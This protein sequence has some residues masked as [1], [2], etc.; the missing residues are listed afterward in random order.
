MLLKIVQTTLHLSASFVND[1]SGKRVNSSPESV[2]IDNVV[3]GWVRLNRGDNDIV[4][5]TTTTIIPSA[6][7]QGQGDGKNE[8]DQN[9][10]AYQTP[11]Q[12]LLSFLWT[13]L[14]CVIDYWG[15]LFVLGSVEAM[16]LFL[17]VFS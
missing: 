6:K 10:A 14:I 17:S 12:V 15:S 13:F 1:L 8:Y 4:V 9:S 11:L 7:C 5:I 16:L 3:I 2:C